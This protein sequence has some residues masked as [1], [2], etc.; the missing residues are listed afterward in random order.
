[1][2]YDGKIMRRAL[3]RYEEDKQRREQ[4]Y[5]Q[6]RDQLYSRIP[7]LGEIEKELSGTMSQIIASALQRGTDPLPAIRVIR[8]ENLQL[9]RERAE[10]LVSYG[11]EA[12]YLD[13]QPNCPLCR[14]SGYRGNDVCRCLQEYYAREQIAELSQLLHMGEE[15]FDTFRFDWYTTDRGSRSRSPREVAERN[16]DTCSDYA[17]HF[18]ERSG[19]LLLFGPP[20]LGKTF[21][22]TL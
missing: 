19:N 20:G 22:S 13:E 8:D 21:L 12:D 16:F 1:M 15:T 4:M 10:L 9:Q 17:R 14:D 18:S 7:R 6:R 3:Q 2:S 11:Y 5:Q